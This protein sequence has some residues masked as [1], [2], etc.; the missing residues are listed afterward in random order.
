M[1]AKI[2]KT[3]WGFAN[4]QNID[5]SFYE[6]IETAMKKTPL[7]RNKQL[8]FQYT[9]LLYMAGK[10]R[11]EPF[12]MPVTISQIED[13]KLSYYEVKS[14]LA[15]HFDGSTVK[16][17]ECNQIF[18]NIKEWEIHS[19]QENHKHY[20]HYSEREYIDTY[21][22]TDNIY[23]HALMQ[24][25]MQG[26]QLMRLDFTPLL[27]A[28]FRGLNPDKL[29]TLEYDSSMFSGITHKFKM[30][31]LPITDGKR[32][33]E[34]AGI[35]P[36]MLRHMRVYDLKIIHNYSNA[37]IQKAFGWNREMMVEYYTDVRSM[38]GKEAMLNEIKQHKANLP[39]MAIE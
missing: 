27:P 39:L 15:K 35:V 29:M 26:R 7:F 22:I 12:L 11:I 21:I 19:K 23:E 14:A 34:N 3:S 1:K 30:F 31:K 5:K 6:M 36:H 16:C 38:L 17:T 8:F 13:D 37:F 10:R 28:K 9:I 4:R 20:T 18:K 33:I 2:Y 32:V 24:Y 25:L